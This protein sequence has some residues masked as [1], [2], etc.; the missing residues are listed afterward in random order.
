V[1]L[2]YD[3]IN[4]ERDR[5]ESLRKLAVLADGVCTL[6][7]ERDESGVHPSLGSETG[8][9]QRSPRLRV[10]EIDESTDAAITL[11]LSLLFGDQLAELSLSDELMHTCAILLIEGKL[12]DRLGGFRG[13]I[14]ALGADDAAEDGGFLPSSRS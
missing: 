9:F 8:P 3:V 4:L 10:H 2:R 7:D 5:R 6:S 11:E 12:Q 13:K 14:I 1:L